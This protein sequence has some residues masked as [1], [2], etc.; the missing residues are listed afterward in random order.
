MPEKFSGYIERTP[1][2]TILGGFLSNYYNGLILIL[3]VTFLTFSLL[4][5][6]GL[7]LVTGVFTVFFSI[8]VFLFA[9]FRLV[10]RGRKV[11]K[12]TWQLQV[13]MDEHIL[14]YET[15]YPNIMKPKHVELELD[16]IT[17]LE[18]RG[19]E[20]FGYFLEFQTKENQEK[21]KKAQSLKEKMAIERY[22]LGLW[23]DVEDAKEFGNR[24]STL[25][26]KPIEQYYDKGQPH[27]I[28]SS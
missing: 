2:L 6:S 11:M 7:N 9:H 26:S 14:K 25:I 10:M 4:I 16:D 21:M 12:K 22:Q 3:F 20:T 19:N 27:E 5:N 23:R 28:P 18:V 15:G 17:Q 13:D 1:A 8:P 24:L